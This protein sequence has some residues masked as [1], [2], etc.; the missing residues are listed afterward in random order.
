MSSVFVIKANGDKELFNPE[1]LLHSLSR[2]GA[3]QKIS[4]EV[5][6]SIE[7]DLKDGMNTG[8]IYRRAFA[9]MQKKEKPAAMR[10]SLRKALTELGPSGFPFENFLAELFKAKGF[11]VQTDQIIQGNCAEH[12]IDLLASNQ[13]K[14]ILAEV[15]FH[16]QRGIKTDLKVALYVSA[17]FDDIPSI[18]GKGHKR[19]G[20]L[21]TNTKFSSSAIRY[22][23]CKNFT[24]IGWNYPTEGNLE[25][26]IEESGLHP[27]TCLASLSRQQKNIFL[28]KDVVLCKDVLSREDI[29]NTAGVPKNKISQIKEEVNMLCKPA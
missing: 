21:I 17:R 12:E 3:S 18:D 1:K 27:L 7:K 16:N 22:G 5:L 9:L 15:K 11:T 24:L 25:N 20:W 29:L 19:E 8:S 26:M 4:G 23:L 28:S 14:H 6:R 13:E 10:Y 2:S